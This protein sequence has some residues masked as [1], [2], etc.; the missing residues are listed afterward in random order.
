ME[1]VNWI[2]VSE[3]AK[4]YKATPRTIVTWCENGRLSSNGTGRNRRINATVGLIQPGYKDDKNTTEVSDAENKARIAKAEKE[5]AEYRLAAN[6]ANVGMT[7]EDYIKAVHDIQDRLESLAAQ[8]SNM[9]QIIESRVSDRL[10]ELDNEISETKI[11]RQAYIDKAD[12]IGREDETL[13]AQVIEL[14]AKNRSLT[15][16]LDNHIKVQEEIY[17][18]MKYRRN[19]ADNAINEL[20]RLIEYL[21]TLDDAR[22]LTLSAWLKTKVNYLERA[23]VDRWFEKCYTEIVWT[24]EKI[25]DRLI[26]EMGVYQDVKTPFLGFLSSKGKVPDGIVKILGDTAENIEHYMKLETEVKDSGE[27]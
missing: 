18:E 2:K 27:I 13:K 16:T 19:N 15:E 11:E 14:K 24:Y 20:K 7:S 1:T 22:G 10:Q 8:E 26:G 3:A 25:D 23:C 21:D 9:N 5:E 12:S 6:A 4:L 17:N